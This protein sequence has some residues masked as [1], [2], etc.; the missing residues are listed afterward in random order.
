[1][2]LIHSLTT[3]AFV[4]V[5][6]GCKPGSSAPPVVAPAEA[7]ASLEKAFANA[8]AEVASQAQVLAQATRA[9][10][11]EAVFVLMDLSTRPSLTPE[12]RTAVTASMNSLLEHARKSAAQGD[13]S[14]AAVVE[15]YRA[16]K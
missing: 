11:S 1:M 4:A 6:T 16:S 9:Q 13:A 12:Q 7:G 3:L 8:P 15:A 10:D 14:A 5:L 2:R